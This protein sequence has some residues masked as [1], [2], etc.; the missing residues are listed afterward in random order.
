MRPLAGQPRQQADAVGFGIG[1]GSGQLGQGRGQVQQADRLGDTAPARRPGRAD[2][3]GDA[4]RGL[5]ERHLVPQAALAQ[6]LAVV[7]GEDHDGVPR[8]PGTVQRGQDLPDALVD[9]ADRRVVGVPGRADLPVVDGDVVGAAHLAQPA[10]VGVGVGERLRLD[11]GQPD[12]RGVVAVPV[13]AGDFP[14]IVRV[15]EGGD[16]QERLAG[17]VAGMVVQRT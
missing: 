10:A 16:Q 2:D 14:R 13:A 12:R 9:V 4:R 3:Q 7:G 1:P 17:V 15:S 8:Q 6:H 11:G 5:E